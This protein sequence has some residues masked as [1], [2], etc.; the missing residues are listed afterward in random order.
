MLLKFTIPPNRPPICS[1]A[2]SHTLSHALTHSFM[3]S[4]A[5][6]LPRSLPCLLP[7]L[8]LHSP[9]SLHSPHTHSLSPALTL[10]STCTHTLSCPHSLSHAL[11][12]ALFHTP[13]LPPCPLMHATNHPPTRLLIQLWVL[14]LGGSF[15]ENFYSLKRVPSKMGETDTLDKRTRLKSLL[16]LVGKG[17]VLLLFP[18]DSICFFL[19]DIF[20]DARRHVP[21][22]VCYTAN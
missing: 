11:S 8:T 1:L 16:F 9:H 19:S 6:S 2:H 7:Y 13:S 15:A 17:R 3:H 10:T 12:H 21:N 14:C 20:Q 5:H 22:L 18:T 4:L